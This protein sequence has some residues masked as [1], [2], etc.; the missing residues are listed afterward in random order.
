MIHRLEILWLNQQEFQINGMSRLT[1]SK[2]LSYY[3]ESTV[4]LGIMKNL[5][6]ESKKPIKENKKITLRWNSN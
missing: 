5:M 2:S 3:F 4:F 6:A 1:S